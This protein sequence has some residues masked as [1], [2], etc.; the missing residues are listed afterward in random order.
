MRSAICGPWHS[1]ALLRT[2]TPAND[3]ARP[4]G[5]SGLPL[6]RTLTDGPRGPVRRCRGQPPSP[7]SNRPTTI[8][9]VARGDIVEFRSLDKILV[10]RDGKVTEVPASDVISNRTVVWYFSAHWCPP[11]RAFT[12]RFAQ[13]YAELRARHG[14]AFEVV[15]VSSDRSAAEFESYYAE[16][17]WAAVP[18]SDQFAR[19]SLSRMWRVA[20][21]PTAAVVTPDNASK[22]HRVGNTNARA[23]IARDVGSGERYPWTSD[24]DQPGTAGLL[25]AAGWLVAGVLLWLLIRA[26]L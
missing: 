24:A 16:M 20:G 9:M 1:R 19:Q 5:T 13:L 22:K 17:P 15:F 11:C 3:L 4:H 2:C 7:A 25:G 14:D 8:A 10:K 6:R 21:I 23:A 18:W 12:P 26:L